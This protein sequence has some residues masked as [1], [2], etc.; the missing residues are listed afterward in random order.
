MRQ[1][2]Q[3]PHNL[4]TRQEE[5]AKDMALVEMHTPVHLAKPTEAMLLTREH[6]LLTNL[7]WIVSLSSTYLELASSDRLI[8]QQ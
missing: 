2:W 6:R 8:I 3:D 5:T 7:T 4:V 1:V